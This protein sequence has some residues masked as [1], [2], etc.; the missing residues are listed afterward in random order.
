MKIKKKRV[1]RSIRIP[2]RLDD[3]IEDVQSLMGFGTK[4]TEALEFILEDW[5]K[6]RYLE[7]KRRL[8]ELDKLKFHLLEKEAQKDRK[9]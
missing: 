3:I 9:P 7:Q 1:K 2:S 4:F 5:E 6:T 8:M